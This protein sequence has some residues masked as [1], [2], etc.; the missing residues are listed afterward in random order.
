MILRLTIE[1]EK[2]NE[3]LQ[4]DVINSYNESAVFALPKILSNE[5]QHHVQELH[6]KEISL[7]KEVD[8]LYYISKSALKRTIGDD[9]IRMPI[10]SLPVSN[11]SN[12]KKTINLIYTQ[13]EVIAKSIAIYFQRR[14]DDVI[15]YFTM[16]TFPSIFGQ[17]SS[18]DYCKYAWQFIKCYMNVWKENSSLMTPYIL[19]G[20][21]VYHCYSFRKGFNEL[22]FNKICKLDLLG[23]KDPSQQQINEVINLMFESF[24][25]SLR[26]LT[27]YHIK[28]IKLAMHESKESTALMFLNNILLPF[29]DLYYFSPEFS[30]NKYIFQY[31]TGDNKISE[32]LKFEQIYLKSIFIDTVMLL[33]FKDN[34]DLF[35]LVF[36]CVENTT[37]Y[38]TFF[39]NEIFKEDILCISYMDIWLYNEILINP[40]NNKEI[41]FVK[42]PLYNSIDE[43]VS[44]EDIENAFKFFDLSFMFPK[45]YKK[46]KPENNFKHS[47]LSNN[48]IEKFRKQYEF[49]CNKGG[50][51]CFNPLTLLPDD[52]KF[53]LF[54]Y[55]NYLEELSLAKGFRTSCLEQAISLKYIQDNINNVYEILSQVLIFYAKTYPINIRELIDNNIPKSFSNTLSKLFKQQM[56]NYGFSRAQIMA[57]V[58]DN[59]NLEKQKIIFQQKLNTLFENHIIENKEERAKIFMSTVIQTAKSIKEDDYCE[60]DNLINEFKFFFNN[61][62]KFQFGQIINFID[63][64]KINIPKILYISTIDTVQKEYIKLISEIPTLQPQ[65]LLHHYAD[66]FSKL[67]YDDEPNKFYSG[68]ILLVFEKFS[69]YI[70]DILS[71]YNNNK[72]FGKQLILYLRRGNYKDYIYSTFIKVSRLSKRFHSTYNLDMPFEISSHINEVFDLLDFPLD[73]EAD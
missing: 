11:V 21:F 68:K 55:E 36:Q 15:L 59:D 56:I 31:D 25:E 33:N 27:K 14:N 72:E 32:N 3:Q 22:F 12:L 38:E 65:R 39:L 20:S 28:A 29:F 66:I 51:I 60:N 58:L 17:F 49:L 30:L 41:G 67:K 35:N 45:Q 26:F 46:I 47:E 50:Q 70:I 63:H 2:M 13:K 54:C 57:N 4:N 18:G 37:Y 48:E 52:E 10:K 6:N 9:N 34:K 62:E 8:L 71:I 1:N 23:D 64:Q 19:I 5:V 69:K 73:V 42:C 24:V 7:Q 43:N 44:Y 40:I 61:F 53:E 16:C